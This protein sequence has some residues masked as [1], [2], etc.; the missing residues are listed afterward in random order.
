MGSVTRHYYY[1]TSGYDEPFSLNNYN[2]EKHPYAGYSYNVN[3]KEIAF[4]IAESKNYTSTTYLNVD[5]KSLGTINTQNP[6]LKLVNFNSPLG[7]YKFTTYAIKYLT[8]GKHFILLQ[9]YSTFQLGNEQEKDDSFYVNIPVITDNHI[10]NTLNN[11][12]KGTSLDDSNAQ[13]KI[14]T[15][16][17]QIK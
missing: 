16:I 2:L 5:G 11:S 6:N 14:N 4:R 8:P 17:Q 15:V 10:N 9:A 1:D 7:N 3:T 12:I 13:S